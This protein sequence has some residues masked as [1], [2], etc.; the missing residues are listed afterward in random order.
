MYFRFC[1]LPNDDYL[2]AAHLFFGWQLL[3]FVL[4]TPLHASEAA[5]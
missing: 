2:L 3:M 5:H 4:L 1:K